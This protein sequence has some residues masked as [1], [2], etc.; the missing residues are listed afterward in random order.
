MAQEN[1]IDFGKPFFITYTALEGEVNYAKCIN[2]P[3]NSYAIAPRA[4]LDA[5]EEAEKAKRAAHG[6]FV[7]VLMPGAHM[8]TAGTRTGRGGGWYD[9]F[10]SVVPPEWMRVGLCYMDQ[11]TT[12]PLERKPWDQPVD[13]VG[14]VDHASGKLVW[15]DTHARKLNFENI[16]L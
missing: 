8:D 15:H 9:Q 1:E 12:Q 11:F 16:T 10:L 4:D 6:R 7:V 5:W 13:R 14:V 3:E 2:V